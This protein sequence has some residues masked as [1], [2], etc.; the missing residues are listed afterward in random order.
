MT[1]QGPE[2][3]F[4]SSQTWEGRKQ[5]PYMKNKKKN[6]PKQF[7]SLISD[8]QDSEGKRVIFKSK[9]DFDG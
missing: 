4:L 1:Y 7:S 2:S 6:T 9:D 3:I 5:N 8:S